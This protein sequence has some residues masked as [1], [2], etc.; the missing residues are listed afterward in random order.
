MEANQTISSQLIAELLLADN[1][2]IDLGTGTFNCGAITSSGA[3]TFNSGSVDADFTV[4]WNTGVGL[5]IE[6]SSGRVGIGTTTPGYILDIDAGEIDDDNYDGLRIIDTGWDATSHPM[7]EFYNSNAQFGGGGPLARIYGEIGSLGQNSKL[8][9][10]VADNSK[11]LQD[12]MVIDKGGN[13]GI[14]LTT[15]DA[16]YK[17][18]IR[19]AANI[20]LGIGLQ[21]SELAIVAFNDVLSANIPMRFYASEYNLLNGNVGI[22]VIDPDA[23]LEVV[24][25]LHV[26]DA[27]TFDGTIAATSIGATG[28]VDLL[29]FA[30]DALTVNG[31]I[32]MGSNDITGTGK[33]VAAQFKGN[34]GTPLKLQ[35]DVASTVTFFED[36]TI[37]DGSNGQKMQ[38]YRKADEGTSILSFNVDNNGYSTFTSSGYGGGLVFSAETGDNIMHFF[39]SSINFNQYGNAANAAVKFY[40]KVQTVKQY[41]EIITLESDDYTHFRRGHTNILGLKV[42]MPL[43]VIG[44]TRLGDG[45]T[46]HYTQINA[47]GDMSFVGSAGFYPRLIR[48]DA[49]PANGTGDTQIDDEELLVWIDTNDANK[50]YMVYN[51]NTNTQIKKVELAA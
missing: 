29:S 9:F 18:I 35:P 31:N 34:P 41:F 23:K 25:T 4:N 47:T 3:S 44:I 36:L 32:T 11:N 50:I 6:G 27:A 48:Q 7:L 46:D 20:N 37:A 39:G 13:V 40:G 24:G 17:L 1:Q 43:D 30:A 12:R 28:D 38:V 2:S 22:N 33:V 49:Q 5:F 14:G 16:N 10:A 8:Y 15:V 42:D 45:G 21:S 51:D 26:S 19:R